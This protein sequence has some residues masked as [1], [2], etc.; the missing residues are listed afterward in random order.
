MK[1]KFTI[2]AVMLFKQSCTWVSAVLV[3]H[4]T[5]LVLLQSYDPSVLQSYDPDARPCRLQDL[6]VCANVEV[7]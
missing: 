3:K 4:F 5:S 6:N 7:L 2:E 1:G